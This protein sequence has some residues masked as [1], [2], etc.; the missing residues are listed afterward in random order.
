MRFL[1]VLPGTIPNKIDLYEIVRTKVQGN[2][3]EVKLVSI[4]IIMI[5]IFPNFAG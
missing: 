5:N 4:K 2:S 3:D 1:K